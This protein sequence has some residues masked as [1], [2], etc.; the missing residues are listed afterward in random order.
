MILSHDDYDHDGGYASLS[1]KIQIR[2]VIR[3][4]DE[5]VDVKYPFYSL[6]KQ[7]NSKESNDQSIINYFVYDN[8]RYLFMA[9][10]SIEVEKD[11]IQ[12]Y[13]LQCDILKVGHH[14]SNTS[15]SAAFLEKI[16]PKLAL[17]SVGYK[18]RYNHPSTEVVSSLHNLGIDTL[19]TK[20]CGSIGIFTFHKFAFFITKDG[21]FGIIPI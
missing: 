19:M 10:A 11:L 8:V 12:T 9:D 2:H 13:N 5:K 6:L 15:S 16:K 20:D 1:K 21:L 7:R 18:N 17:I 14:G 4:R 3:N